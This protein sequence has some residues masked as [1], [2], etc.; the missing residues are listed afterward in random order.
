MNKNKTIKKI[1][2]ELIAII[3]SIYG[4][5][6]L[7]TGPIMFTYFT[8]ISN[9]F[10]VVMLMISLIKDCIN[11]LFNKNIILPNYIYTL[12]YLATVYIAVTFLNYLLVV[13]PTNREGFINSYLEN[14]AGSFC[15]HIITPILAIIDFLKFDYEYKSERK[16]I[17]MVT[18]FPSIYFIGI[19]IA[20]FLGV[21]W[22]NGMC[23]PYNF[24][25]YKATTGWLGL[26]LTQV[27]S[28]TIGV[29]VFY[30]AIIS[31]FAYIGVGILIIFLRKFSKKSNKK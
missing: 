12:K 5:S 6:K 1:I 19:M 18:I 13:A 20:S 26:D 21:T 28:E 27:N 29:G 2:I 24:L 7:I 22:D 15:V 14:G 16:H 25:N 8:I 17:Y 11:I 31:V 10:I 23:V 30:V 9:I 4:M 3:A